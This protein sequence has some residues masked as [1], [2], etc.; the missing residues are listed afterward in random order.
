MPRGKK[1]EGG[2]NGGPITP[3]DFE[4]AQKIYKQDVMPAHKAQK[5]A[6]K[7]AGDAW[8]AIKKECRVHKGGYHKA[9]QV[10]EM[11]EAEQQAWLRSF[12]V[13]LEQNGVRLHA[14]AVDLMQGVNA[15]DLEV[16]P[17][18]AA[19]KIDLPPVH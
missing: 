13:G 11:E 18:G 4:K 7:E 6:M 2:Q 9:Q 5:Q 1:N 15:S 8:K 3:P 14:D 16:V 17:T 19:D 12:K 10:S